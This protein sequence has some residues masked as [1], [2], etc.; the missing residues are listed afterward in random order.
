MIKADVNYDKNALLAFMKF[1]VVDRFWKWF[2]HGA[3]LAF[4]IAIVIVNLKKDFLPFAII[5][6][7]IVIAIELVIVYSYFIKPKMKLQSFSDDNIIKNHF[8]FEENVIKLKSQTKARKSENEIPYSAFTRI[9]ESKST[10]YLFLNKNSA[11]IVTK[12]EITEGTVED[13]KKFL[14]RKIPNQKINKLSAK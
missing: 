3:L 1:A 7:L 9:D 11:L 5:W 8:S 2:I 10:I 4:A 14:L 12:S 6:L 13:L